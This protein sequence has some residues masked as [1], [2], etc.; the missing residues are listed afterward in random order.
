MA[1]MKRPLRILYTI[2]NFDTAG[3]GKALLKIARGLDPRR[4]EPH[5]LCMHD[6]GAFFETVRRS[7]IPVH[8]F[9][10]TTPMTPRLP[11]LR[12][13]WKIRRFFA[14]LKVDL[15]HSF[16]YSDEYS[17]ALAARL[18]GIRWTFTKKN[19]SWGGNAWKVRS[20]LAHGIVAQN[21]DMMRRFFPGWRKVTLIPR[22]VD[23]AEFAPDPDRRSQWRREMGVAPGRRVVLTVANLVP[24]KGV[25]VLLEAFEQ[26]ASDA[27]LWVVGDDAGDYGR[28]LKE[29]AASGPAADRIRF[30]GKVMNVRDYLNAAD[31]FVLPT[32][33]T[34]EGSPV[35]MLEAMATGKV[36]LGS[37]VPGIKDQ[38]ERFPEHL[39]P[40]GSA[41][42]LAEKLGRW[43][44]ASD[45]ELTAAGEAFRQEAVGRFSLE[46]EIERHQAFYEEVMARPWRLR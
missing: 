40:A 30:T 12:N 19:M 43:L 20:A 9:Q 45:A 34:G 25:E 3:S 1:E 7:G 26:V 41:D 6:R 29:R 23:V 46:K 21:T 44:S 35:A 24:V 8:L 11:G 31:I 36:V 4:F 18:A 33:G 15:I 13:V 38:L 37:A 14:S 16:H 17:E 2:P 39:F 42:A 10:Y 28:M 32:R 5:I 27:I 22:G